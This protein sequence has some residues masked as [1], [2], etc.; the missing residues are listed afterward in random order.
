MN[1]DKNVKNLPEHIFLSAHFL[2]EISTFNNIYIEISGGYHSTITSIL[3]YE[4]GYKNIGLIH[5]DTK[6]QYKECLDNI[7]RIVY[8]TDYSLIF[9]NPN[10]KRNL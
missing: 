5:N 6:L 9:K 8:I 1:F 7:Q 4:L 3:F 10:L 2:K